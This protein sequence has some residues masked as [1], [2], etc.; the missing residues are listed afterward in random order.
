MLL[1]N[2]IAGFLSVR[3]LEKEVRHKAGFLYLVRFPQKHEIDFDIS[4]G[5]DMP[6]NL[7]HLSKTLQIDESTIS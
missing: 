2:Q 6:K 5:H 1:V 4:N 7:S 3:F